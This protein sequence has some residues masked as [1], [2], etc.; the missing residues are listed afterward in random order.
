M[1]CF[2]SFAVFE[3]QER[4][5][6]TSFREIIFKSLVL[7]VQTYFLLYSHHNFIVFKINW[8]LSWH[9]V[10]GKFS[11]LCISSIGLSSSNIPITINLSPLRVS[12]WIFY[13]DLIS[14]FWVNLKKRDFEFLNKLFEKQD[15]VTRIVEIQKN[16]WKFFQA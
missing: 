15:Y 1:C 9:Q 3:L 12:C 16:Q 10:V 2:G 8:S 13:V 14:K 7:F 5:S 6:S 11:T 4:L